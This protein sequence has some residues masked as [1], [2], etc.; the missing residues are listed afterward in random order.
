M[1]RDLK[2]EWLVLGL[3]PLGEQTKRNIVEA[4]VRA[5]LPDNAQVFFPFK[6]EEDQRYESKALVLEGYIFI[7]AEFE[8]VDFSL[9]EKSPYICFISSKP[10]Y[11]ESSYV[12]KLR[13]ELKEICE[14]EFSP[15]DIVTIIDGPFSKLE[16]EVVREERLNVYVRIVTR[17]KSILTEVPKTF[18]QRI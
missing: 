15:G 2:K 4:S 1:A 17:S 8:R 9:L 5:N 14:E 12:D 3:T 10:Q 13:K 18:I 6:K 16:A 11:I 7:K